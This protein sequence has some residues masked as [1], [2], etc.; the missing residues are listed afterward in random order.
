MRAAGN[1]RT[2]FQYRYRDSGNFK[3][4][5]NV[6]L[7]GKL[8]AAEQQRFGLCLDRGEFFIAEQVGVPPLYEQLY[9]WSGGPTS[10]DHCWH[11]FAGFA[12]MD[13]SDVPPHAFYWGEAADFLDQF[14]SIEQWDGS[15][16]PHFEMR[17]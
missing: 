16:S 2:L 17:G 7:M 8:T 13:S 5:G 9:Q 3:A 6:V 14:C 10:S 4:S 1:A 15:L 11:E 12:E